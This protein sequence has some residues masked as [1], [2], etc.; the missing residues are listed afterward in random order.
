[1]KDEIFTK[2][3][4]I[5]LIITIIATILFLT[6][7]ITLLCLRYIPQTQKE[8]NIKIVTVEY[9]ENELEL[10]VAR[11]SDRG[12]PEGYTWYKK[13]LKECNELEKFVFYRQ[14]ADYYVKIV[15]KSY[16]IGEDTWELKY[17]RGE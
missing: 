15:V 1:M 7:S 9:K 13:P 17:I 3:E 6:I 16:A 5:W 2:K 14:E 4:K 10:A 12:L 8:Y 11:Y